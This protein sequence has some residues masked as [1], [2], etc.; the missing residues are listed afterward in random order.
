MHRP[1]TGAL[2]AC[3]LFAAPAATPSAHAAFGFAPAPPTITDTIPVNGC[4][5]I[6]EVTTFLF[7]MPY[8][9][10]KVWTM[11]SGTGSAL[12]VRG[13]GINQFDVG[14]EV[15][16]VGEALLAQTWVFPPLPGLPLFNATFSAC[17]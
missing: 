5:T 14:D 13:G 2:A 1:L 10:T 12:V 8:F 7:G 16:I 17:E 9:T 3:A 6:S 15:H 11:T 4:G